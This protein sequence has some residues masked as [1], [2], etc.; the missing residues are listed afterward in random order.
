MQQEFMYNWNAYVER[1]DPIYSDA[2]TERA[3]E[4]FTTKYAGVRPSLRTPTHS[5]S[6]AQHVLELASHTSSPIIL[7]APDCLQVLVQIPSIR[8][9]FQEHLV[10][11][12][13][14][15]VMTSET[16]DRC[17]QLISKEEIA[18]AAPETALAALSAAQA[19]TACQD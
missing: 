9:L 8:S 4:R 15:G 16:L 12:W 13:E 2:I 17:L 11:Q 1:E 18:Q 19:A 10:T 3:C 5:E 14:D 6:N 7:A